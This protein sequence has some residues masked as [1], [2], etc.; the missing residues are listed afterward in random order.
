LHGRGLG[1]ALVEQI[2]DRHGGTVEVTREEGAVF[3]VR[4]PV[5]V[6]AR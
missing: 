4:L 3:T 5:T 2:I 1:L 6:G